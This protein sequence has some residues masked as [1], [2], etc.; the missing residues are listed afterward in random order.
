MIKEY[1]FEIVTPRGIRGYTRLDYK[2]CLKDGKMAL[3]STPSATEV[4]ILRCEGHG[5]SYVEKCITIIS[6]EKRK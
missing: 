1:M 2:S 3:L 5:K 6:K 4:R